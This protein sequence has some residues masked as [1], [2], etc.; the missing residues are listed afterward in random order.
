[1]TKNKI[2]SV[3]TL[4]MLIVDVKYHFNSLFYITILYY[5]FIKTSGVTTGGHT[6]K[7]PIS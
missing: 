2:I 1:M 3:N 4:N 7:G 5:K 6:S